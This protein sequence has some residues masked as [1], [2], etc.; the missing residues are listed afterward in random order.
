MNKEKQQQKLL[1]AKKAFANNPKVKEVFVCGSGQC[2]LAESRALD[3]AREAECEFFG[4]VT[5]SELKEEL[6]K[7]AQATY[8]KA[9]ITRDESLEL[10][11]GKEKT[12]LLAKEAFVAEEDKS[13]K[14]DETEQKAEKALIAADTAYKA[15]DKKAK[16]TKAEA[17]IEAAKKA[18]VAFEDA[19]KARNEAVQ[20]ALRQRTEGITLAETTVKN[21][22]KALETSRKNTERFETAVIEA[23]EA[24]KNI[25][26]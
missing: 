14:A 19:Q 10:I 13:K 23:E 18:K 22:E 4:G 5:R 9:V 3:H 24:L 16:D 12:L 17:D 7:E 2:F 21:A 11:T 20:A 1:I 25:N 26:A 8:K 6:T 15:A